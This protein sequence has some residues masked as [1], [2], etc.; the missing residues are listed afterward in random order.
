MK[1]SITVILL[2]IMA[3]LL[4]GCG[5]GNDELFKIIEEPK[6]DFSQLIFFGVAKHLIGLDPIDFEREADFKFENYIAYGDKTD[7]GRVF[8]IDDGNKLGDWGEHFY[9]L[10]EDGEKIGKEKIFPNSR[11]FK[12]VGDKI[13]VANSAYT[14]EGYAG[15]QILDVNSY[16]KLYESKEINEIINENNIYQYNNAIYVGV[17]AFE[18]KDRKA[19][20]LKFDDNTLAKGEIYKYT[21]DFPYQ[22]IDILIYNDYLVITYLFNRRVQIFD[23]T[24]DELVRTIDINSLVDIS[25]DEEVSYRLDNPRLINGELVLLL[26]DNMGLEM[27]Y[28][29]LLI[30]DK[31]SLEFEREVSLDKT[32]DLRF[33]NLRYVVGGRLFFQK[34]ELIAIYDYSDGRILNDIIVDR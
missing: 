26:R 15:L 17:S 30:F 32:H 22:K 12:V 24:T 4:V 18:P 8:V 1:R 29:K 3:I 16:Q 9:V 6:E 28:Q 31:D 5:G 27:T 11:N 14:S 19:H 21:K 33:A 20:I 10:N 13:F 23:L 34:M 2:L 7:D 25:N